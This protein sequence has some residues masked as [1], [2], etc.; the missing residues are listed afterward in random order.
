VHVGEQVRDS[1]TAPRRRSRALPLTLIVLATIIGLVSVFAL[2]VKRQALETE[3]WTQ[4]S[5]ELLE[6]EVIRD[7]VAGFMV[8]ALFDNVDV[9][10]EVANALPPDLERLAGPATG[11]LRQLT[12]RV[13]QELLARP[14]IQA[15]WEDANR[16]AHEK[17]I[18]LLDDEAEFVSTGGG[19][20]TL[21]L[22]GVIA[23]VTD[24]VG[25][26]AT[27][28]EKLPEGASEIKVLRSD[29]LET[30]QSAITGLRTLAYVL[31]ALTLL[32]YAVAIA[33]ARGRRQETL[34]A[35]GLS[36]AVVGVVVLVVRNVAGSALTDALTGTA[37]AGPPVDATWEIGTSLLVE[38][39]QSLIAYG[40]AIV[41]AAWLAGHTAL[42]TAIR[43]G[44]TPYL[45]RPAVAYGVVGALLLLLFW[46]DPVVA[47][48]RLVPSLVLIL[49]AAI[50]IEALRRQ[51]IREF[52]DRVSARS[53]EGLARDAWERIQHAREAR[54]QRRAA[55]VATTPPP[56]IDP[57]V[58][59]LERLARL[60]EQGVLN[61]DE[62]QTEKRRIMEGEST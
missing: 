14:R 6:D 20:V 9:Q 8:D 7:A 35:V 59:A 42:A 24:A 62:L 48:S 2:W 4:T 49:I 40:I 37:A 36:F 53:A 45:R 1:G 46:W 23:E 3:T 56:A 28:T 30:A 11:G 18:A 57:R 22:S 47:T 19:V 5:S 16:L 43:R 15:L 58:D 10:S 39:G 54:A 26:P 29:E 21:D 55:P 27:L 33:A 17:L 38:T 31:T 34:R 51:V 60:R 12:D 13:A 25:L 32:L 52:P 44:I 41:I 50:G 61:D